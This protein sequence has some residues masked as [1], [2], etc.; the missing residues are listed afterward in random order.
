MFTSG[1]LLDLHR[2]THASLKKLLDH[3][4]GFSDEPLRREM[5]GF[6]YPTVLLQI[7]HVIGAEEYWIGV[8]QGLMLTEERA[9]DH[10][11][12]EALRAYRERVAATTRAYLTAATDED[13]GRPR[14]VVTWQQKRV[15]VVPG[16]VLLRTQ[17]HVFQHQGQ[18]AA[19]CRLLGRPIPPGL[20]FPLGAVEA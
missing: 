15:A 11:S 8:L 19:M 5:E 17:T 10:A 6:G 1:A 4:A 9:S 14:E 16:H 18:V 12:V 7:H 20:D 3:C 2:R 13:L